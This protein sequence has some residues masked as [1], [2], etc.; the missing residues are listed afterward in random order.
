[1]RYNNIFVCVICLYLFGWRAYA[2]FIA[3]ASTEMI[4]VYKKKKKKER[5]AKFSKYN[6]GLWLVFI[7]FF[8]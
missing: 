5:N 8:F 2:Q 1:M 3:C 4:S 7:L 6:A